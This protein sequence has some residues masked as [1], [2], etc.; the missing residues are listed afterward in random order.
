MCGL[1]TASRACEKKDEKQN[2]STFLPE[3]EAKRWTVLLD[4]RTCRFHGCRRRSLLFPG[5]LG[6]L[7]SS[8]LPRWVCV[9][10]SLEKHATLPD[11]NER[12]PQRRAIG[13]MGACGAGGGIRVDTR[14]ADVVWARRR[15]RG[16][17]VP[18]FELPRNPTPC[19]FRKKDVY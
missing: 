16:A 3:S 2:T 15:G 6:F 19:E 10:S 4:E 14:C 17:S 18:R 13:C 7:R 12:E 11:E 5:R 9:V 1:W 8:S